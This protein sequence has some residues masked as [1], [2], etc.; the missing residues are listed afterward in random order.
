MAQKRHATSGTAVRSPKTDRRNFVMNKK[1]FPVLR[2]SSKFFAILASAHLLFQTGCSVTRNVTERNIGQTG[3]QLSNLETGNSIPRRSI[4]L[5]GSLITSE[6]APSPLIMHDTNTT[7]TPFFLLNDSTIPDHT[8][9]LYQPKTILSGNI[10][11]SASNYF[12]FGASVTQ[13]IGALNN[14]PEHFEKYVNKTNREFAFYLRLNSYSQPWSFTWR[15]ELVFGKV[16]GESFHKVDTLSDS[17]QINSAFISLSNT[18][19]VRYQLMQYF[20]LYGGLN[21]LSRP[22]SI[23]RDELKKTFF[24]NLYTGVDLKLFQQ[25]NVSLFLINPTSSPD[26]DHNFEMQFG[27]KVEWQ[28]FFRKYQEATP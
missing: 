20:G 4:L 14:V 10:A 7:V 24:F 21:L 12:L 16:T 5:S 9:I 22:Y 2:C 11:F 18:F 15:P 19:V 1:R 6:H 17:S 23:S 25:F 3:S 28:W 8:S 13:S 26:I 27:W